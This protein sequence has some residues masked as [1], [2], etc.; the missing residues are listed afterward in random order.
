VE[1]KGSMENAEEA[2]ISTQRNKL[3]QCYSVSFVEHK[4]PLSPACYLAPYSLAPYDLP[5]VL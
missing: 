2:F 4:P 3:M 5:C 1:M